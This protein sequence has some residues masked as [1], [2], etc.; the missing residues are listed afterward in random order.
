[1]FRSYRRNSGGQGGSRLWLS[2][3][4]GTK[5]RPRKAET[6]FYLVI[7]HFKPRRRLTNLVQIHKHK[8]SNHSFSSLRQSPPFTHFHQAVK[9]TKT[10]ASHW[11]AWTTCFYKDHR[12]VTFGYAWIPDYTVRDLHVVEEVIRKILG[13]HD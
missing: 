9:V 6:L 12:F 8:V 13:I 4:V 2:R 10:A 11:H 3:R 5:A 7:R 1:M